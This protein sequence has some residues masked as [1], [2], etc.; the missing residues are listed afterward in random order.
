[1]VKIGWL[2]FFAWQPLGDVSESKE[3]LYD[4]G[5]P[6]KLLIPYHLLEGFARKKFSLGNASVSRGHA[7]PPANTASH[8]RWRVV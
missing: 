6:P 2:P 5:T 8:F 7:S 3:K 4:E 1:M